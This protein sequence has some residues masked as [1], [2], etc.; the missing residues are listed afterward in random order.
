M[1]SHKS[2]R[3]VTSVYCPPSATVELLSWDSCQWDRFMLT[4]GPH[5]Q[6]HTVTHSCIHSFTHEH[7]VW[8]CD[9]YEARAKENHFILQVSINKSTLSP[10]SSL[11]TYPCP[12]LPLP[13]QS[14]HNKNCRVHWSLKDHTSTFTCFSPFTTN[15]IYCS[16]HY[17]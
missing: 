13:F 3:I 17:C 1:G 7:P 11:T 2:Q 14:L 12:P 16:F 15:H 5:A 9:I 6:R 4:G 8:T 10:L